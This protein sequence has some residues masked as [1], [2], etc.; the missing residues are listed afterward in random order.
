GSIARAIRYAVDTAGIEHIGL[1]SDFDGAVG[2]PFDAT[3]LVLLSDALLD[4]GFT[5]DE[6]TGVMGGNARR[7]LA[8]SLPD[9]VRRVPA[10]DQMSGAMSAAARAAPSVSTGR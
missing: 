1:G 2:V 6:I 7:L 10:S 9:D 5:D 4:A 3:G 8:E